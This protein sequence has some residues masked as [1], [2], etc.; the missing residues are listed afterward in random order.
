[1]ISPADG[2]AHPLYLYTVLTNK[3]GSEFWGWLPETRRMIMERDFGIVEDMAYQKVEALSTN[4]S[5]ST[6]Y[7]NWPVF[8]K[9]S[10][11]YNNTTPF[12]FTM[13]KPSV[14]DIYH[15]VIV[16][17]TIDLN[18]Y[19]KEMARYFA[20]V[21]LT[22]GIVYSPPPLD[23]V[24]DILVE[25]QH[26]RNL[27]VDWLVVRDRYEYFMQNPGRE[28]QEM[29][30]NPIDLQVGHLLVANEYVKDQLAIANEQLGAGT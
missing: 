20:A 9:V 10:A 21:F 24:Q 13:Q 3:Y 17:R 18:A 8:E 14:G 27:P 16:T 15:T 11:A 28:D 25:F 7:F 22:D 30:L 29:E 23:F 4:L 2:D 26:S 19:N 12:P 6:M 1:M 5:Q